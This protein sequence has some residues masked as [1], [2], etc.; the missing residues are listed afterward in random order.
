WDFRSSMVGFMGPR[1]RQE[2]DNDSLVVRQEAREVGHASEM[3]VMHRVFPSSKRLL[4]ITANVVI[5]VG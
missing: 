4:G 5:S 3:A 2:K 1:L